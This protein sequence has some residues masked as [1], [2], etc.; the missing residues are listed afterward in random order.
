MDRRIVHHGITDGANV[1]GQVTVIK[2][3]RLYLGTLQPTLSRIGCLL[4]Q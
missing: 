4:W 1:A 2:V 3:M